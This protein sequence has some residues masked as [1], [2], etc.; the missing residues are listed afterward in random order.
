MKKWIP[1][2]VGALLMAGVAVAEGRHHRGTPLERLQTRLELSEEQVEKL[3]PAFEAMKAQHQAARERMMAIL[4]PEQK[5]Q[6]KNGE[7]RHRW[8]D[9]NLSEEQKAQMK[10]NWQSNRD[11]RKRQREELEQKLEATLTPEQ[12]EKFEE[13]KNQWKERHQRRHREG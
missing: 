2:L 9:L 11:L 7:G 4:T 6:L 3:K 5:E 8:R 13:M 1:L 10:A 12:M